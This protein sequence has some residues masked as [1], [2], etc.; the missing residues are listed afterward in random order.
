MSDELVIVP[1]DGDGYMELARTKTGRLF[2]KH[3]LNKGDLRHPVTGGTVKIDDDFVTKLKK[4]F[5]DGVCDIVQVP[6]A[7]QKNEHT[8]D[9]ER[10]IGEVVDIEVKGD[11]VYAVL[12][13]RDEAHADKLGKTY[14]GASAMLSLDYTNTKTGEKVGPTLLH[15]CV[16]NRPYVTGLESYEEIV[17]ATTDRSEEAAV[18]LSTNTV[19]VETPSEET[20]MP[21]KAETETVAKPSLEELLTTLKNE[22]NIDVSA[23]Q[24]QAAD[25]T[26][27]AELSQTIVDALSNAGVV[28]LS[29]G[30]DKDTVGTDT[31]V[32]AVQEL[33]SSNVTLSN[34]VNALEEMNT[35]HLKLSAERQVDDLIATGHVLP[36]QK[37]AMVT[38]RLSDKNT[39]DA[40]IPAQPIVKLSNETGVNTP[41]DRNHKIDVDAEIKRLSEMASG[42]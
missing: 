26:K 2:R 30:D 32:K 40:L 24:A 35:N 38:L 27:S 14:L 3:L 25:N 31:V 36:A 19:V 5:T 13:I 9:P 4:N 11:K 8:E 16:T 23:L 7:N 29:A 12:D 22:H 1:S 33:A 21:E 42:K 15:S 20:E 18:L 41:N 37:N 34:R 17:A 39:F 10:N 6:L 28:K